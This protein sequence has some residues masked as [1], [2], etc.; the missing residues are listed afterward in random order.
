MEETIEFY[1]NDTFRA[2]DKLIAGIQEW[3]TEND[4]CNQRETALVL[5]KLEEARLWSLQMVN[6]D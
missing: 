1:K 2:L 5:T 6:R 3:R 4:R